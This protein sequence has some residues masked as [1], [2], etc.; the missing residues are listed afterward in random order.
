MY[1][2]T[3]SA[4]T[5][6]GADRGAL[7]SSVDLVAA[8]GRSA[9]ESAFAHIT[10]VDSSLTEQSERDEVTHLDASELLERL[11]AY[12]VAERAAQAGKAAVLAQLAVRSHPGD[13]IGDQVGVALGVSGQAADRRLDEAARAHQAHPLLVD[14]HGL[15]LVSTPG[16]SAL[17]ETVAGLSAEST[18]RVV[19]GVLDR[20]GRTA[21]PRSLPACARRSTLLEHRQARK[22]LA[23]QPLSRMTRDD[24]AGIG[25]EQR[26]RMRAHATPG[27]LKRWAGQEIAKLPTEAV[28]D[29]SRAGQRTACVE[30]GT[31][32]ADGMAYLSILGNAAANLACFERIDVIARHRRAQLTAE[33]RTTGDETPIASLDMLRAAVAHDLI[34]GRLTEAEQA[35]VGWDTSHPDASGTRI[36]LT[37]LLDKRGAPTLPRYG[38]VA[39][40]VLADLTALSAT[41][42]GRATV[43]VLEEQPCRGTHLDG[44]RSD[45]YEPPQALRRWIR[46]R[47]QTCR[48]PGCVRPA[49]NCEQ[50]HTIPWPNGPTCACN[51]SSLCKRH[52]RFKHHADGWGLSNHG[53]GR[54]TWHAPSGQTYEAEPD[55]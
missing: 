12:E 6:E 55:A 35:L 17:L 3:M 22:A 25:A 43:T 54:L 37:V 44:G 50:D 52:H 36:N 16:I 38:L 48:F 21:I 18:T 5:L 19:A 29:A 30:L 20:L 39:P 1:D 9:L 28:E 51:L 2:D 31:T 27:Q 41:T 7:L 53:G 8:A 33:R 32:T 10:L 26:S 24:L 40:T 47:D 42:G 13:R 14:V 46:L 4:S 34:L 45:S 11:E 49:Q 23:A 15:G